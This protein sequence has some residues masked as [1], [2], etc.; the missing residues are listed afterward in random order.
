MSEL[1]DGLALHWS[2]EVW[3]RIHAAVREEITRARCGAK[4]LPTFHVPPKATT[5]PADVVKDPVAG[6]GGPGPSIAPLGALYVDE[7]ATDQVNEIWV[8]FS[9]T[10][11]Q[12]EEE[13]AIVHALHN[14]HQV[15][16]QHQHQHQQLHASTGI[17]LA[18]R[19]ANILAQVED[20]LLFQG[21]NATQTALIGGGSTAV[22]Y[23]LQPI[24][25]GLLNLLLPGGSVP[26]LLGALPPG[27]IVP[28]SPVTPYGSYHERTVAAIVQAV[29]ILGG[30]GQYGAFA[31]VLHTRPYAD[32][33]SPLPSTLITPAEPIRHL[34][35]A[36]FYGTVALPPFLTPAGA[37]NGGLPGSYPNVVPA[38]LVTNGGAGYN[39]P[40]AAPPAVTIDLPPG[41]AP[42]GV[43]ATAVATVSAGGVVTAITVTNQGSGYVATP[44]VAIVDP[45]AAAVGAVQATAEVA[46]VRYTGFVVS[47]GGNT[48]D[49]VR[50][51]MTAH[52]DVVVRF[53]QKDADGFYR[54]RVVER[55]AL[56]LKS[57]R[58]VVQ[59]LFLAA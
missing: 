18:T 24:D 37:R 14:Q 32:A 22:G 54:F 56:R 27:Q 10:G 7:T 44:N 45:P 13:E 46:P 39:P 51:R 55:F 29:S 41:G 26:P 59:L 30:N 1:H 4:F 17:S 33:H 25:L 8:E 9:L 50:G 5:V 20:S 34:M 43:R 58:A 36:G 40:P 53:E 11:A 21:Q 48:M 23:R 35:N 28:V 15:P 49:L 31:A 6:L 47:L 52:E 16:H 19:A 38:I 3:H 42:P 2:P 57:I 12:V